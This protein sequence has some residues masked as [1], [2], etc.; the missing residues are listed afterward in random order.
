[1]DKLEESTLLMGGAH[2]GT[3][4]RAFHVEAE[5][6][7]LCAR[8]RADQV[9]FKWKRTVVERRVFKTG[10]PRGPGAHGSAVSSPPIGSGG[11]ADAGQ[12]LSSDPSASWPK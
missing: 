7:A 3:S 2:L 10:P 9:I 1:M 4:W 5:H 11:R 6:D 8:V 12:S